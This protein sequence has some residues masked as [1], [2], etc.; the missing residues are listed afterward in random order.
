MVLWCCV[1]VYAAGIIMH[2][3]VVCHQTRTPYKHSASTRAPRIIYTHS[4]HT[5]D[6]HI[7]DSMAFLLFNCQRTNWLAIKHCIAQ[8]NADSRVER[9]RCPWPAVCL[10]KFLT[11][12]SPWTLSGH[13]V[14][15]DEAIRDDRRDIHTCWGEMRCVLH[16]CYLESFII[17]YD[18]NLIIWLIHPHIRFIIRHIIY[19][20]QM[21]VL[22]NMSMVNGI[23][24]DVSGTSALILKRINWV[25]STQNAD[26][27]INMLLVT[28]E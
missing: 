5:Y 6:K 19:T 9:W 12:I 14:G 23:A 28:Y 24:S 25:I 2:T 3:C 21:S 1:Y 22:T 26:W 4:E 20:M 17:T 11:Y 10:R 18:V 13:V 8:N 7:C 27:L 16:M 15:T